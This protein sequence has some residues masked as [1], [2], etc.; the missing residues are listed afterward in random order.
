MV[1]PRKLRQNRPHPLN[2]VV[3]LVIQWASRH[4][5]IWNGRFSIGKYSE[6]E[7]NNIMIKLVSPKPFKVYNIYLFFLGMK[8][9]WNG[10]GLN[11]TVK[12]TLL[13]NTAL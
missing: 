10:G 6:F 4:R 8:G 5:Y 7:I 12:L 9:V 2:S 13:R 11:V 3:F 1:T